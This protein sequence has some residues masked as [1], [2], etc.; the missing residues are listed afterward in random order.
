MRVTFG[1]PFSSYICQLWLFLV[2][3]WYYTILTG[4]RWYISLYISFGVG[5]VHLVVLRAY[6]WFCPGSLLEGTGNNMGCQVSK[7]GW[8]HAKTH[9]L[10]GPIS[11]VCHCN[12]NFSENKCW[13][14]FSL[15]AYWAIHIFFHGNSIYSFFHLF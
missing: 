6:P 1:V 15:Y 7:A 8:P 4:V 9:A 11:L 3:F 14:T 2:P 10:L 5:V 12:F 13:Q